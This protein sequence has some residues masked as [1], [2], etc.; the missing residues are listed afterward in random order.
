[1]DLNNSII[2]IMIR[3]QSI[4]MKNDKGRSFYRKDIE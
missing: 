3:Y 4:V 1:M 2:M